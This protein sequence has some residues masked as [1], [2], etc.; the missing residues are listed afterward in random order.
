MQKFYFAVLLPC[1]L[2]FLS[3][4]LSAQSVLN[5]SDTI[6]NYNSKVPPTQPPANQIGKWVRTPRLSWNTSEYKCYIFNGCEFRLHFPKSYNPT[7]ND[8]KKYPMMVFFHGLGEAGTIYDN[9]YQLYHG[10]DVFQAAVDN[11][12]FDGYV[13]CMQSQGYW[14]PGQYQYITQIIDYMVA[15]NKLDPFAVSANGLSAGGQGTWEMMLDHPNYIAAD[16]PMSN[17]EIG[18]EDSSIVNQVKFTPMWNFQGGL[19]GAPAPSTAQQVRDAMWAA[20]G[21][22]TYT[23]FPTQGHDTWDSAWLMPDFFPFML[24]AYASNPWVLY[25]RTAF[26]PNDPINVTIGVS[27]GYDAYQWELNGNLIAGAVNN[28][29]QA[30][31]A[32]TYSARVERNGIWS[33][34]SHMP[35][36]VTT[37]APTVTPPIQVA[38]IMSTALPAADGKTYVN[39]QVPNNY[40]SYT[41]KKVGSDSIVGNQQVF[42]ATQSG[43]Y[44][45]SVTEQYGCSSNYSPAFKVINANGT[46]GPAAPKNLSANAVSNTQ[47]QL[48]WA[49]NA[50][51]VNAPIATEVYR[52]TTSG[53]PYTFLGQVAP[54]SLSFLDSTLTP[55]VK[56][57][58]VL[59]AIDSTA[60]SALSNQ[61][62]V[63]TSSDTIPP[64]IPSGLKVVS[65]T[66]TTISISWTAST[67]NVSVDHYVIYVNGAASNVTKQTSFIL[68]GI[69][70]GQSYAIYVK[71][72]DG[73][74][75]YSSQS[76]QV[77]SGTSGTVP[78]VPTSV[79]TTATAYNK[80]NITWKDN[81][82]NETGFEVYR[83]TSSAGTYSIVTTTAANKTSFTDSSLL[84]SSTYF[85]KVQA[86][87]Q[88]GNS[89]LSPMD[90]LTTGS[91]L[92]YSYYVGTWTSTPNF[93]T[94]TPS[95]TGTLPNFSIST[96]S[97]NNFGF[98]FQGQITIPTTGS[99][100][101]YTTSDNGSNLYIGGYTS[102]NLV[103][104]NVFSITAA[105]K[106]G[107]ITLNAG[108]YPIYVAYYYNKSGLNFGSASL[109]VS[110]KGP[111]ISQ[112]TIPNSAFI[113]QTYYVPSATTPALPAAPAA[114]S[115]FAATA[116]SVSKIALSWTNLA[117]NATG[118]QIYRSISNN[119]TFSLLATLPPTATSYTD[120]SL[121]A[122]LT[123]YYSI[124]AIG[125]GGTSSSALT[126]SATTKNT[127][128]VITKLVNPSAP[129]GV[130]T[131]M[132]I[133][134]T[135]A[136]GDVLAFT[137][138]NLPAFASLTDN[139]NNTASLN[140]NP[141]ITDSGI[142]NN[143]KIVV[144]D[145]YGG[146]DS[147][148][149][150]L[151]INNNYPPVINSIP[152]YTLNENDTLS[153]PLT[154]Q[155]QTPGV[156]LTWSVNN[157]PNNFT[158]TQGANNS[159]TL[160]LHPTYA[161]SGVYNVSANVSDGKGGTAAQ[162]FTITV[163]DKS[164]TTKVYV[165]FMN[166]D[167]IGA[168]WNSVTG[169]TSNNFV[170][171]SGNKTNIGLALQTSW[172]AAYNSGPVTGNNSGIYPDAVLED[173][174]YFAIF[175]GPTSVSANITGLDTSR[176]YN[177]T[178][179]G[180]SIW[181]GAT[182]NGSTT[183][184]VGSQTDTLN[185]QN[186]TQNAAAI[187][188]VKPASDGTI[189]FVMGVTPGTP[190]GY[191]NALTI[192]SYFDDGTA[193]AAPTG[194]TA[195][196]ISGQGVQL[197]WT[198]HAYNETG[199]NIYR[200]LSASGPFALVGQAQSGSVTYT[201][202]TVSGT[203]QYSYEVDA[204]N[205]RGVSAF[206]NIVSILTLDRIPKINP[207]SNVA[208]KNTQTSTVTIT[209]KDDSTDHITLT[210]SGL[211]SFAAF[212]DKGNGTGTITITP[213]A[214]TIGD[215]PVTVTA[216]DNSN[217]SQSASFNIAV[218]DANVTSLYLN[219]SD[220]AVPAPIPW[221]NLSGWPFAGTI[222]NN[223]LDDSNN[224]SNVT[225]TFTNGFQGV[226]ESGMQPVNG[227]GIYPNSVLRTGEFEGSTKTDSI[228]I[229]GLSTANKYNF[230]FFASHDDGLKG[231]TNF[232]ISG[233]TVTLN[234]TDNI[235]KTAQLNGISPDAN[236]NVVIA[237]AK[238]TGADYAYISSLVIQGYVKTLTNLAP[239]T[240]LVT[241][242]TRTTASIQW[243]D[244]SYTETGYQIWRATS[245]AGPYSQLA[246][247]A[248]GTTS[249]TDTKLTANTTYYYTVRATY[250]GSTYSAYSSPAA[251]TTC[252][253]AVYVN[254]TVSNEGASPWNN[255]NA[256]PQ[257]GYT[258]N[259][260][261]DET[262]VTTNTGMQITDNWAGMYNAG[263]NPGNNSGFVP[264]TV[265][266]D[267]Y[268]LFPGQ[269]GT[270]QMTGLNLGMKY[271]FTFFASS[272]AY[273]DVNVA[274]T[275]NGITAILNTSLNVN[276][277][278]TIYGVTPD[279]Y[280]NVTISVYAADI[281]SQ[282]GLLG[283]M[284]MQGFT[285][286]STSSPK[287]PGVL[288]TGV[289]PEDSKD[290][291]IKPKA[292]AE[293]TTTNISAYPN[294]F[295]DHFTLSVPSEKGN[296]KVQVN[297][298]TL[299][300]KLVYSKSFENLQQG[301][302]L[303]KISTDENMFAAGFYTV[304]VFY[305]GKKIHSSVS[306]VKQ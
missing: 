64:S 149:F 127:A 2:F 105:Q 172:W 58:Y 291:G 75:N 258:W 152:N 141:A 44:I 247:L 215:Y 206:S 190:V 15:N 39:L 164:P 92:N 268:G 85:Y 117:T 49:Q 7:A 201:D 183:Y 131:A 41:W 238:A 83:S 239:T 119:N 31:Q 179:F 244:R 47:I 81:S 37:K 259:N 97:G 125:T 263:M 84:P 228:K 227:Q 147:T 216:T 111:N 221:N 176:T 69:V 236:G 211:P 74:N 160:F 106:S 257:S 24:R 158:L 110:Y 120:S 129:Y 59:R 182:N 284:I 65:T 109:S 180:S 276:G 234:A 204:I 301:N 130:S 185:V 214:N 19:D 91:G 51:P 29:I 222:F 252:A 186:N 181:P 50:H 250:S 249:Y 61:A 202:T 151:T 197:S 144:S 34:W 173:Y 229:S 93:A 253:Y 207:I 14:G 150:S 38:G 135:D 290:N 100:T 124:N 297:I 303:I 137:A 171:A 56:Y 60:A 169:V 10:G 28:S 96:G 243:Q 126:A 167:S 4:S 260:F 300:G 256:I 175:G 184:T 208:L 133:T 123:Y 299:E 9:E 132:P 86:I 43:Y 53:G 68:N 112:Q 231:N 271:N 178:F 11:G 159:A 82:T 146:K 218:T 46:N 48:S 67:D 95:K 240:L 304:D 305:A 192:I 193:P 245:S 220:G 139:G 102:S 104:S 282:Y 138:Q 36:Q 145:P 12:T 262:G 23:E 223:L 17:V 157:P 224:P 35:A 278:V 281:S 107:T 174:Y 264:D 209:A 273:G 242:T 219:F 279:N 294:P 296:E 275:I 115:N 198:D 232:T 212:V 40:A 108:V 32:G 288:M 52:A 283:A 298:Y 6:V 27:P 196:N 165:R 241:G 203:T 280:G 114:P 230:V 42:K 272:Q 8:G 76:N 188:N 148:T 79:A 87:N 306:I 162:Q 70:S 225:V 156:Q 45:V 80:I 140:L 254:Y 101:F 73:S 168:P 277:A 248:A 18:Y 113:Q 66:S 118:Y 194:L 77:S 94:L 287:T 98:L 255:T 99:Y 62:S 199:Y 195:Q 302:N 57:F 21:N 177:L 54:S 261:L 30:T 285:P 286:S 3:G 251:A 191:I 134:A 233:T 13:L 163:N 25:G 274:Y 88:Y 136:D 78:A 153:I 33:D 22:Y 26:C 116:I 90:T 237:V 246:S 205:T 154:A 128:P 235:S 122:N 103:V 143:L 55:K 187:N 166:Q 1:T 226:V 189:N 72:V 63:S 16:L 292:E 121:G 266:I 161:A 5:P 210:V 89:G 265:M 293:I 217:A 71:A 289:N 142:Y 155:D 267:S 270:Y 295:H 213:T 200:S 269:K 20:G 170:D